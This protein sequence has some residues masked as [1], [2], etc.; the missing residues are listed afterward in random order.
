MTVSLGNGV[1][2]GNLVTAQ[3][4][5]LTGVIRET[6]GGT[7]LSGA[8]DNGAWANPPSIFRLLC[9]GTGTITLDSKDAA[10]NITI[11]DFS[12][13]LSGAVNQIEFPYCGDSSVQIRANYTGTAS[14]QVI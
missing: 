9:N 14:A 7:V 3:T 11:G 10:G 2:L 4:N 13:T 12:V 8:L 1:D 6:A 5:P